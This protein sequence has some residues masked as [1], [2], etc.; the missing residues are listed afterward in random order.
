MDA[1]AKKNFNGNTG[2]KWAKKLLNFFNTLGQ[3]HRFGHF[4]N[5]FKLGGD[6]TPKRKLTCLTDF[7]AIEDT[8]EVAQ[9]A[10]SGVS[11]KKIL[12]EDAI[13]TACFGPVAS[14]RFIKNTGTQRKSS[15][16][17]CQK[18]SKAWKTARR[19]PRTVAVLVR[20][21]GIILATHCSDIPI[22][23]KHCILRIFW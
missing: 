19:T 15:T 1:E 16:R 7:L 23:K 13:M 2:K 6:A 21:I 5:R 18:S 10:L 8:F 17:R 11:R 14:T 3:S 22:Q 12:Q 4:K 9:R 20:K